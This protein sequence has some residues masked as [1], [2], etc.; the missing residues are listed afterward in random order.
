[1]GTF[2]KAKSSLYFGK[3]RDL[4]MAYLSDDNHTLSSEDFDTATMAAAEAAEVTGQR[5]DPDDFSDLDAPD[6]EAAAQFLPDVFATLVENFGH[7]TLGLRLPGIMQRIMT[8]AQRELEAVD[9]ELYSARN[10]IRDLDGAA[11]VSE[12]AGQEHE[13][14]LARARLLDPIRDALDAMVDGGAA[15]YGRATGRA[16]LPHGRST[17]PT[18]RD[19]AVAVEAREY[20]R[21]IETRKEETWTNAR[22]QI[23]GRPVV[24]FAGA[25]THN[26]H[27]AI[28]ALLDTVKQRKADFVLGVGGDREGAEAAAEAW[29]RARNVP[30][31]RFRP[32]F[33]KHSNAS[34]PFKRNDA[35]LD[36][37]PQLVIVAMRGDRCQVQLNMR[38]KAEQR[39]IPVINVDTWYAK[40]NGEN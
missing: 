37:N 31:I 11:A 32:E 13:E 7:T 36:F 26:D 9:R 40:R 17:M 39:R 14:V 25:R 6:A 4:T 1:M 34:A 8:A 27:V 18:M 30:V 5:I 3:Q 35:V 29:A 24:Y 38:Q 12:V 20:L 21:S 28:W 23:A 10:S 33:G 2:S 19:T 16:W 22:R 15:F